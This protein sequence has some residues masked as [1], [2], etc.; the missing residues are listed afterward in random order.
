MNL[1][2][3]F[4]TSFCTRTSSVLQNHRRRLF[5][6][7]FSYMCLL[8]FRETEGFMRQ[9]PI[10][11]ISGHLFWSALWLVHWPLAQW[12]WPNLDLGLYCTFWSHF[13][14]VN[15]KSMRDN[16]SCCCHLFITL[17]WSV[18]N[19]TNYFMETKLFLQMVYCM[20]KMKYGERFGSFCHIILFLFLIVL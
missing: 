13:Q 14:F 6:F 11:C 17:I 15:I 10:V 20:G 16:L 1:Q 12:S 18:N 5:Q 8:I 7:L 19:K 4:V 9:L 2:D 3:T